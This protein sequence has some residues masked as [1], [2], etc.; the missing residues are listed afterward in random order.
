MSGSTRESD[1]R[2]TSPYL[3]RPRRTVEEAEADSRR[4]RR[5]AVEQAVPRGKRTDNR[6]FGG[7]A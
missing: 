5:G 4:S 2:A 1:R 6:S 7:E 3:R